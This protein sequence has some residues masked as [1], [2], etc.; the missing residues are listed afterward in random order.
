[1]LYYLMMMMVVV[2]EAE[3]SKELVCGSVGFMLRSEAKTCAR[4]NLEPRAFN[5]STPPPPSYPTSTLTL[6][7]GFD[8]FVSPFSSDLKDAKTMKLEGRSCGSP[9]ALYA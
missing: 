8:L 4:S 1:M 2:D 7:D 9:K 3:G 6:D 5:I